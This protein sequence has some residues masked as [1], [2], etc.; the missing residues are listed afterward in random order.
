M[1]LVVIAAVFVPLSALILNAFSDDSDD[2][3]DFL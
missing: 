3:Y 2:D 1:E